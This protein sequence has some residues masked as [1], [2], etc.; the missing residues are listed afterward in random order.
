MVEDAGT[1]ARFMTA[2]LSTQEG[3]WTLTGTTRMHQRPIAPLVDAL[4]Q[5]GADIRYLEKP[6]HLPLYI[7]G[8]TLTG[9]AIQLDASQSSQFVSALL[10]ISPLIKDELEIHFTHPAISMPYIQMTI[11][12][13]EKMGIKTA[14][15]N[16]II[17]VRA[18]N[19]RFREIAIEN[20][21]SS[22]AFWYS[23]VALSQKKNITLK[24]PGLFEESLQG[25]QKV[26]GYFSRMG[27]QTKFHKEGVTITKTPHINKRLHLNLQNEPDL[28]QPLIVTAAALGIEAVFDGLQSLPLKES[29]RINALCQELSRLGA[30]ITSNNTDTIFLSKGKLQYTGQIIKTYD[31][32]RMAMAFSPL[33]MI[34]DR[35]AIENPDVVRKSYPCFWEEIKK[36]AKI[37][38]KEA[39][40]DARFW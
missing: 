28:A 36:I 30:K 34:F 23:I 40:P 17:K 25:D 39:E 19:F 32:H 14:I 1:V 5:L 33:M 37:E 7:S 3:K 20:D 29:N 26:A 11:R 6:G 22:S 35:I 27:V 15:T 2:F 21:W 31:D 8:Q 16:Q 10:L 38:M 4:L 24:L 18:R 13:L 9:K 12:L